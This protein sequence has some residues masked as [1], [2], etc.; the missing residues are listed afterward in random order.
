M[1]QYIARRENKSR[2]RIFAL[3]FNLALRFPVAALLRGINVGS[4]AA[5]KMFDSDWRPNGRRRR[6]PYTSAI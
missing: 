1:D 4:F 6:G 2:T 3:G 5:G